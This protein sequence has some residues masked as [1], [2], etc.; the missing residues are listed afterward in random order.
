MSSDAEVVI[1]GGGIRGLAAALA[2]TKRVSP[3]PHIST[4]ELRPE[5]ATIGGA[6]NLTRN[7]LRY[8]DHLGALDVIKQKGFG[9]NVDKIELFSL[10]TG[11]RLGEIDFTNASNKG[12]GFDNPP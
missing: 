5:P 9:A 11:A 4:F 8:L 12:E 7:A 10:G 3:S 2:L 6:I 1:L